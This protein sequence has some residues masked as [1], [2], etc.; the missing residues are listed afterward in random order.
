MN[1]ALVM[2]LGMRLMSHLVLSNAIIMGALVTVPALFAIVPLSGF[3]IIMG[4]VFFA[5]AFIMPN[6][7]ALAIQPV[8]HISGMASSFIGFVQTVSGFDFRLLRRS[9]LQ[10]YERSLDSWFHDFRRCRTARRPVCREGT[11]HQGWKI[12]ENRHCKMPPSGEKY[13]S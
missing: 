13:R 5:Y 1:N 3:C 10:L 12:E 2:C 4:G 8:G 7:N 11:A 6:F 9:S